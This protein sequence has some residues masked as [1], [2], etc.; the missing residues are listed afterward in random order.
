MAATAVDTAVLAQALFAS[1]GPGE[2]LYVLVDAARNQEFPLRLRAAG[3]AHASLYEASVHE[4]LWYVAPYLA[5]C[6]RGSAFL[7]WLLEAGWGRSACVFA[8][9][10]A[11][12][13]SLRSH[14]SR[15]V[16]VK[17]EGDERDFYFRF[18][19]P[20]VLRAF[21][22]TCTREEARD[23]FGPIRAY[24]SEAAASGRGV[25]FTLGAEGVVAEA[26]PVAEAADAGRARG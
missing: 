14:L 19:D 18:Y 21:L 26:F 9:S 16:L 20:R 5:R 12:L 3:V 22:P 2:S 25:K 23:F 17:T 10:A 24:L 13:A 7:S 15:F 6:E 4:Q 8:A 11:D 1:A